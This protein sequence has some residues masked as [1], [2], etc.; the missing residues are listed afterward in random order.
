MK[1]SPFT[2]Q[3]LS[4]CRKKEI[5]IAS[6]QSKYGIFKMIRQSSILGCGNPFTLITASMCRGI[7]AISLWH[8]LGVMEAQISLMLA[9]GSSFLGLVPLIFLLIIPH[10][11]SMGFRS[12]ELAGK[13]ST[14]MAWASNQVLVLLAVWAGARSYWKMKSPYRSSAEG[15]MK[16][17]KTLVDCCGDLG[18][19]KAKFTNTCTG[20][21]T[22]NHD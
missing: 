1:K 4:F 2:S 3:F 12:G 20:H 17:S 7:D 18:F 5:R 22:L 9:V 21:H 10:R 14:V 16:S 13:S 11:F 15:T 19:K 8:C 6:N